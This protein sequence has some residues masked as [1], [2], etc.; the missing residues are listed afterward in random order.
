MPF[1]VENGK[2]AKAERVK[3]VKF[4]SFILFS[5][6]VRSYRYTFFQPASPHHHPP[7]TAPAPFFS[8][9]S[10]FRFLLFLWKHNLFVEWNK[11]MNG[12]KGIQN[13][14]SES[15]QIKLNWM[16]LSFVSYTI[17]F[18][19]CC[20]LCL[21]FLACLLA[22]SSQYFHKTKINFENI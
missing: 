19:C 15:T 21:P 18:S 7:A 2:N 1:C 12:W 17:S 3:K 16:E 9:P 10:T 6:F 14:S 13:E 22:A 5:W 20:C 4:N 8:Q 11:W